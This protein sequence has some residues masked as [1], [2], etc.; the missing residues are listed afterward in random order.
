[1]FFLLTP[2]CDGGTC[3]LWRPVNFFGYAPGVCQRSKMARHGT[4]SAASRRVHCARRLPVVRLTW[5]CVQQA[6]RNAKLRFESPTSDARCIPPNDAGRC[7]APAVLVAL[8]AWGLI[9]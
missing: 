9:D 3:R 4:T 6:D 5:H 7:W 1:M 8:S 2:T